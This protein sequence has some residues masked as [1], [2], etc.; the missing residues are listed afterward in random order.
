VK[1]PAPLVEGKLL[2][3]YQRFLA[4]VELADGSMVTAH[5]PNT[6]SMLQCAVAGHP[7]LISRSDNPAR[8][9]AWTLELI[10]VNGH[11][12]DTHTHRTNRV[13][14]EA[15]RA[16]QLPELSGY[17]VIPEYRF[18][19][20]RLD[21]LLRRGEEQVFVEVKNVTLTDGGEIACF[22]DAVTERG[23]RHLNELLAAAR[24][25]HR[26]V[27]FFLVQ[28]GEAAAFRPADHI[29]PAYGRTLRAVAAQ[30]VEIV[31]CRSIVTPE[32]N[33]VGE[34]LPVLL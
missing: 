32:E 8:K 3:R 20:S 12:V 14:E 4:D 23:R 26:A 19:S 5:T 11:W 34:R 22:P 27:I 2:R 24:Q 28:R 10:R 29:D 33:R 18:G 9:L 6:G 25:G 13:V 7:V 16:G 1:L 21:F 31:A 30:G 15:L 17:Q